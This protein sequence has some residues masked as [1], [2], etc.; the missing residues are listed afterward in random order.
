M[1]LF[2]LPFGCA[3]I[4]LLSERLC[5]LEDAKIG[6]DCADGYYLGFRT[7]IPEDQPAGYVVFYHYPDIEKLPLP[8]GATERLWTHGT[9][10]EH[11]WE[12][13]LFVHVVPGVNKEGES[14]Y[15]AKDFKHKDRKGK[16]RTVGGIS[17]FCY[18][19]GSDAMIKKLYPGKYTYMICL[20]TQYDNQGFK[21]NKKVFSKLVTFDIFDGM[22]TPVKITAKNI[23]YLDD[24]FGLDAALDNTDQAWTYEYKYDD[25]IVTVEQPFPAKKIKG[26]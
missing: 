24:K 7:Y 10:Y 8:R 15:I 20:T 14:G 26:F 13:L 18:S 22:V 21:P 23:T 6:D 16:E 4:G 1:I 25:I 2:F 12:L 3:H 9:K 5:F 11:F 17:G 19:D